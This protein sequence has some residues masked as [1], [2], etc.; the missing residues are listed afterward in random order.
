MNRKTKKNKLKL[1]DFCKKK[2]EMPPNARR[3]FKHKTRLGTYNKYIST[4]ERMK[5]SIR[6]GFTKT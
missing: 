4:H 3:K 5:T 6:L 2:V 1:K